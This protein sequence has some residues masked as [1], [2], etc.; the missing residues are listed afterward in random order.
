M[1][2]TPL[3]IAL[4]SAS[5]LIGSQLAG[6]GGGG[7]NDT[8]QLKF[9]VADAPVDGATA[10]VVKFTGVEVKPKNGSA[11]QFDLSTPR[12]VDLLA[13]ASGTAFVLLGGVTLDAG[14]YEFARLKV[15]S[16]RNT[17][18]SYIDLADGSRAPLFVP[19]GSESGLKLNNGFV[20]PEG[21]VRALIVDFDLRRSIVKPQGQ[22]AYTLKPVL[23]LV[24]EAQIGLVSGTVAATQI[25]AAGCTGDVNTGAGNAVYIYSGTV[26]TPDDLGGSGT[27]PLVGGPVKFD[28]ASGTYRYTVAYLPAGSYTAAFTCQATGDDPEADNATVFSA[29]VSL[30]V[31]AGSTTTVNF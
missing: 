4:L 20:V 6:C 17:T 22:E 3:R 21:G 16:D 26:A 14:E 27:Q 11:V 1:I 2:N 15:V 10:V 5:A 31:T 29:P 19:S 23:R 30:T 25:T 13:T 28:T 18:D 8:G 9:S 12:S 24:D 7:S